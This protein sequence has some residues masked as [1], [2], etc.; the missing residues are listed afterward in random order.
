METHSCLGFAIECDTLWKGALTV[1]MAFVIFVACVWVLLAAV[2]G[3]RM[4]YLVL[5]VTLSGWMVILSAS[6]LFGFW[7]QGVETP[8]NLGPRGSDPSWVVVDSSIQLTSDEFPLADSYPAEPWAPLDIEASIQGVTGTVQT[9]LAEEANHELG[10]EEGDPSALE[11]SAF[12][13]ENIRFATAEDDKTSLAMAQG[14]FSGGGPQVT[15]LLKHDSGSIPR[16]SYMFL[17]A[18]VL[19]FL[20]HLPLLDR[21]EK[22]R[23][24]ILTGGDAPPWY[25]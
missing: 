23:K 18:S 7:A 15:V 11:T 2:F 13:V 16:Y 10:V 4:G 22:S 14:N 9:F 24:Q 12:N 5:M 17:G 1:V 21:A 19:L 6:W 3:R 8:T 25:G 20:I